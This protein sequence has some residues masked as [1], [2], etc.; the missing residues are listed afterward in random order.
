[1]YDLTADDGR[2][3]AAATIY[4]IAKLAGVNPSTVSRALNNPGRVTAKPRE[5]VEQ[6]ATKLNYRANVFA[7]ALPTGRTNTIG[8]IVSDITNPIFFDVIRVAETAAA[9][10]DYTLVLAE[11]SESPA[12]ELVV[13]RDARH[14]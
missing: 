4:D 9:E 2:P 8:L 5:I 11:S 12:K 1:M 10:A 7:R 6:A 13:A 14:S 3:R